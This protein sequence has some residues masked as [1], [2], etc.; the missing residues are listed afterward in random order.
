MNSDCLILVVGLDGDEAWRIARAAETEVRRIEARY[1]RFLPSSDLTRINA[2]AEVG[3]DIDIDDETA[4]LISFAQR[5]HSLSAGAFDITAG[6]LRRAWNFSKSELPSQDQIE[7]LLP[8]VGLE[9]VSLNLGRLS[10]ARSGMELDFGGLAKEYAADR[11][12]E[13]CLALGATS[14][15]VNLAGDVRII[16]PQPQGEAWRIGVKAPAD[17]ATSASAISL[18]QGGLATSGDYERFIEVQGRRYGHI[19]DPRTGWPVVG[20][21]SVTV[22][23]DRCLAAGALSTAAMA[24]GPI[25][26]DWLSSLKVAWLIIEEQGRIQHSENWVRPWC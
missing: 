8:R 19:L 22:V 16:G 24:V 2:V 1:S 10:F 18:T 9:K 11:A 23:A 14:G 6:V 17:A 13:V 26:A 20:A 25:A 4:G 15:F 7:T 21:R 3:G 12:A 5:C